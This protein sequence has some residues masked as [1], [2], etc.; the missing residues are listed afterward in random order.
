METSLGLLEKRLKD[1]AE[2]L[3]GEPQ[4]HRLHADSVDSPPHVE[5]IDFDDLRRVLAET[6]TALGAASR[7]SND[8]AVVRNW[9][10]ARI[11]ALRRARQAFLHQP[12]TT[13]SD[14]AGDDAPL[15]TLLRC[16]DDESA[17]WRAL[18][19][20]GSRRAGRNEGRARREYLDFKS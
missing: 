2:I 17:R 10:A 14:P 19:A 11:A 9:F 6:I 13:D 3:A 12:P 20:E 15:P 7:Q 5:L 8:A 16:F 18:T 4:G 1:F